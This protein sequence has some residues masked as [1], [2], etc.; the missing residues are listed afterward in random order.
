MIFCDYCEKDV[1]TPCVDIVSAA[2]CSNKESKVEETKPETAPV[3]N[4]EKNNKGTRGY[5]E[6]AT[7]D[8]PKHYNRGNI[9]VK[10]FIADQKFPPDLANAVK[11]ICRAGFKDE[12]KWNEDLDKA[13]WYIKNLIEEVNETGEFP[14]MATKKVPTNKDKPPRV[15][16]D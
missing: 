11:Y 4:R 9:E 1:G 10:V 13:I 7:V 3:V 14:Y 15:D 6:D 5:S 8:H 2:K 16:K 12:E